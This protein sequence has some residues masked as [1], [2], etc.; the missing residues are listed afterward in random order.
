MSKSYNPLTAPLGIA[1]FIIVQSTILVGLF[2][3]IYG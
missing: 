2:G 3:G 1:E